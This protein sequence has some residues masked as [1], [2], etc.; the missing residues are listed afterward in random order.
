MLGCPQGGGRAGW[1]CGPFASGVSPLCS[2]VPEPEEVRAP[3]APLQGSPGT[4]GAPRSSGP[5]TA[6][7]SLLY[8]R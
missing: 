5:H 2:S 7:L 3:P 8:H 1:A 4:P 6:T